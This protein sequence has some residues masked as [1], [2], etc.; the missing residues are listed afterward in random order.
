MITREQIE[1]AFD[2]ERDVFT[3]GETDYDLKAITLLRE[4]IPFDQCKEIIQ[5]ATHDVVYLCSVE[6]A[7]PFLSEEDLAILADC[8]VWLK[9]DADCFALFV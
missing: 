6:D 2:D 1:T 7:M 4:R 5:G 3:S 9:R 8:N